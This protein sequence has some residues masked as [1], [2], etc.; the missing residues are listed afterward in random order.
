MLRIASSTLLLLVA[1]GCNALAPTKTS[2]NELPL[3]ADLIAAHRVTG[4]KSERA[5]KFFDQ[6]LTLAWAFNHDV[7]EQSFRAAAALD[8]G[9]P[10]PWWGVALVNGPHINNPA[11][12]EEHSRAAWSAWEQ[13]HARRERASPTD[14]ELIDALGARYSE[15]TPADRRPLDEAYAAALGEV[16]KRHPGD[17]DAGAL[18]AE[19]LMDLQPWDLWTLEGEPKG[20]ATEIV[21]V[22]EAVLAK[23]PRHVGATHL[24]IHAIEASPHPEKALAAAN[25]LRDLVPGAGHLVHMP[26][27]IDLRLG[28]FEA[29]CV[30][31]ERAI[32]ADRRY[33]QLFPRAGFYRVYMAH[34]HHFL[35]FASMMQGNEQRAFDAAKAMVAG[36]P[37]EFYAHAAPLI[38][39]FVPVVAHVLV[40]F[41]RWDDILALPPYPAELPVA[42]A[43]RHYARGTALAALG[44]VDEADLELVAFRAELAR[45][46][47]TQP[48][49]NNPARKVLG[50]PEKLLEGELAYRRG[51]EEAGLA[52]LREA[53][54]IEDSLV[55]DE[56]PD[57]MMPARHPLGAALL[58]SK[59]FD[60]AE[61]VFRRDLQRFPANGW[62]LF[63]L[64]AAVRGLGRD[65]EADAVGR[66]FEGAWKH[67]SIELTSPCFCQAKRSP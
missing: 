44:R 40:R 53:V 15:V 32:E 28:D 41:G 10:M 46:E 33:E 7:A 35:A 22:L 66:Q 29:A 16:W 20:R 58:A 23:N 42:N 45:V 26:A 54:A 25:V 62:S 9:D 5:Q 49:G 61:Q 24:Y 27:H 31:N 50:I 3:A 34:N 11:M 67:S 21:G 60:A 38:D 65:A 36:I 8:G 18:Y 48:I 19:A 56:P 57:W 6:G 17:L 4:T 30:A 39:G 55:Y 64:R 12:D 2:A 59:R 63:G 13:A 47:E 52:A 1:F 14:R 43:V 37:D 51:D